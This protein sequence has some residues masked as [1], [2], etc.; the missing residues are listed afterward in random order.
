MTSSQNP[1]HNQIVETDEKP[2]MLH[3]GV[4]FVLA[5]LG[6]FG[7]LATGAFLGSLL[8]PD[9]PEGF[10]ETLRLA[11]VFFGPGAVGCILALRLGRLLAKRRLSRRS[12]KAGGVD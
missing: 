6:T 10:T 1:Y 3:G 7:G 5:V 4:L 9:P 12:G 2:P 11:I 8:Q